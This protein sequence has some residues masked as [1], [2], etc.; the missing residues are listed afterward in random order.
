MIF[1]RPYD[2]DGEMYADEDH[3]KNTMRKT[4]GYGTDYL[5]PDDRGEDINVS[6]YND[7][8][9]FRDGIVGGTASEKT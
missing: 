4:F 9:W 3:F 5:T 8:D 7:I 2:D 1:S 6:D